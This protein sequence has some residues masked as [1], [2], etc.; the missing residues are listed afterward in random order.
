MTLP[1]AVLAAAVIATPAWA[2]E[3]GEDDPTPTPTP[4]EVPTVAP[5]PPPP[6]AP[7]PAPPVATPVPQV[8]PV[9]KER[10][11]K[12]P[13]HKRVVHHKA[14]KV[15]RRTVVRRPVVRPVATVQAAQVAATPV[16]GVQ[17]GEGGTAPDD[18][19]LP[20]G[21]LIGGGL[22]LVLAGGTAVRA[23]VRH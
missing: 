7:T 17:A 1:V 18:G 14:K 4:T 12:A 13:K 20:I 23:G 10:D 15:V 11:T 22:L 6:A 8:V 9:V 5:T 3:D 2:G 16:G 19:G 21:A